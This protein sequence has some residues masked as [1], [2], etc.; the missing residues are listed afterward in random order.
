MR[1][2]ALLERGWRALVRE[3]VCHPTFQ[4]QQQT[5]VV[6]IVAVETTPVLLEAT[7]L[8]PRRVT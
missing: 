1:A 5:V 3:K 2:V 7:Q 6:V 4:R 8:L